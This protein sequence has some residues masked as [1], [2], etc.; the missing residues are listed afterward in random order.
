MH[1][2]GVSSTRAPHSLTEGNQ[3]CNFAILTLSVCRQSKFKRDSP[4]DLLF[5]GLWTRLL[6]RFLK[7]VTSRHHWKRL[8]ENE[9]QAVSTRNY[10]GT[11]GSRLAY[12]LYKR[13]M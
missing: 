3:H 9:T 10:H 11:Y 13:A 5:I 12:K 7:K 4:T 8:T 1:S 6:G 2:P